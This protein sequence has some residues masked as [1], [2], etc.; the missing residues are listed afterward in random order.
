MDLRFFLMWISAFVRKQNVGA[1]DVSKCKF[2]IRLLSNL[3]FEVLRSVRLSPRLH[4][5]MHTL[6]HLLQPESLLFLN[7]FLVQALLQVRRFVLGPTT[8]A[9]IAIAEVPP[10]ATGRTVAMTVK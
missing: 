9:L 2:L 1:T 6:G 3:L 4:A 5:F 10:L 7:C 8:S